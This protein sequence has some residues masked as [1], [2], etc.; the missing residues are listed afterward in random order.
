MGGRDLTKGG[1]GVHERMED[2][3]GMGGG[4]EGLCGFDGEFDGGGPGALL[5]LTAV[6]VLFDGI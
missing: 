2:R 1:R 3:R 4:Q 6:S 5:V